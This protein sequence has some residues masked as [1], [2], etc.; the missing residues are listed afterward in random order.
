MRVLADGSD[1]E[2]AE[3]QARWLREELAELEVDSLPPLAGS[4]SVPGVKGD[5]EVVGELLVTL[6]QPPQLLT[7]AGAGI[8]RGADGVA[9]PA[10]DAGAYEYLLKRFS[11]GGRRSGSVVA[12][13]PAVGYAKSSPARHGSASRRGRRG[14]GCP[15]FA[16]PDDPATDS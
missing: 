4:E 14:W 13:G 3:R 11:D 9:G 1:P 8:V 12:V 6:A 2:A 5:A 15:K 10:D 16:D 7:G